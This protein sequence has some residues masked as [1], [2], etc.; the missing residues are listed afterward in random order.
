MLL[1]YSI[2]ETV[3]VADHVY[4]YILGINGSETIVAD[5]S[6]FIGNIILS[7]LNRN[8]DVKIGK[9]KFNKSIKI[10]IKDH[11]YLKSGVFVG[12]KRGQVFN[13]LIDKMFR[14]ELYSH[15]FMNKDLHDD[16]YLQ[17]IRNFLNVYNI[18]EDDLKLDSI[19]RDF[20]RKKKEK[21]IKIA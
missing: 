9:R 7:S 20:K 15:C 5:R 6:D 14:R 8:S 11:Q 16:S 2:T 3:P 21:E 18:S 19:Y 1:D 10:V 13:N 17:I 4:K 12:I